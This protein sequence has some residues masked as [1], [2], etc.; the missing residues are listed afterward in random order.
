LNAKQNHVLVHAYAGRRE[1][2]I[3]LSAGGDVPARILAEGSGISPAEEP[4]PVVEA[5][6][7]SGGAPAGMVALVQVDATGRSSTVSLFDPAR[8]EKLLRTVAVAGRPKG[9]IWAS[10]QDESLGV[11]VAWESGSSWAS[12]RTDSI[13]FLQLASGQPTQPASVS[14]QP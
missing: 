5:T 6:F 1:M 8:P 10:G 11:V 3:L 4:L 13:T 12:P 2:A 9:R 14:L 7:V